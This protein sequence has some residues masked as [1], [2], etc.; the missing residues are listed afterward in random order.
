[1]R[2]SQPLTAFWA[3]PSLNS[4]G[5]SSPRTRTPSSRR[6]ATSDSR[7]YSIG[8]D[9]GL[10]ESGIVL[11]ERGLYDE[12]GTVL[13]FGLVTDKFGAGAPV[14]LR[15]QA[16]AAHLV[17][18]ILLWI[19]KHGITSLDIGIETP[20]Y[21]SNA[22]SHAK[23][24]CTV[25]A[26][27]ALVATHVSPALQRCWITEVGPS[28]SKRLATGEGNADKAKVYS[29]SPF[30]S[31][32]LAQHLSDHSKF[33]LGDAWAHSLCTYGRGGNRIDLTAMQ[34]PEVRSE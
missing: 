17:G 22:D 15:A 4:G 16:V 8:L 32:Q 21:N 34:W 10:A 9:P 19:T 3:S 24:W 6:T 11:I 13:E 27:E 30:P 23:Q 5:D 31:V 29:Y 14:M 25:Q 1:M 20:I 18:R 28:V 2:R 7:S 33:T 26:I 12:E